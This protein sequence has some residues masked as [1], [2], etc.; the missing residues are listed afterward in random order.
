VNTVTCMR[1]YRRGFGLVIAFI[2]HLQ[3][4]IANNYNTIA[5]FQTLQI[6]RAHN[7]VFSV[8]IRRFQVTGINT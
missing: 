3:V 1:D 2:D 5:D 6:T 4:V 8:Y 7:L